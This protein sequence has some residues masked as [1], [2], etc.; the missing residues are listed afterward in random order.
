MS[1]CYFFTLNIILVGVFF[2]IISYQGN[3]VSH[4]GGYV[5]YRTTGKRQSRPLPRQQL[6]HIIIHTN[7]TRDKMPGNFVAGI[8]LCYQRF[9]VADVP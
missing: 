6:T 2:T 5:Q 4:E 7:D 8:S 9:T 3:D 1:L